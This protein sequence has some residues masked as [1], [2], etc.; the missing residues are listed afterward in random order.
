MEAYQIAFWLVTVVFGIVV[1]MAYSM[2][3]RW[4][5]RIEKNFDELFKKIDNLTEKAEFDRLKEKVN[6]HHE[7]IIKLEE[8]CKQCKK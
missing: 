2:F 5:N 7:R 6:N 8:N 1:T 4:A 3:G